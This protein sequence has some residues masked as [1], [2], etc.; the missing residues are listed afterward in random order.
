MNEIKITGTNGYVDIEYEGN[1]ARFN[2]DMCI[3]GF[4]AN[5]NSISWIKSPK[6][7]DKFELSELIKAVQEFNKKNKFKI[8]FVN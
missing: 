2:G 1:I 4:Y 6:D 5:I 3:D 7:M 8:Y